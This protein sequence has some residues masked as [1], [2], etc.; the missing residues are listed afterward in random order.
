MYRTSTLVSFPPPLFSL[1]TLSPD[2]LHITWLILLCDHEVRATFFTSDKVFSLV[3]S[4]LSLYLPPFSSLYFYSLF[5]SSLCLFPQR[6][7]RIQHYIRVL[8]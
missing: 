3:P 4:S 2:I 7:D 8:E 6:R 5:P 1:P